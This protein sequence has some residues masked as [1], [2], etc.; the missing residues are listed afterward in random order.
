VLKSDGT[1]QN[2]LYLHRDYQGCILAITD[3]NAVVLEKR[4]FDAWG[5]LINYYNATGAPFGGWGAFDRGYTGHEHLQSV[6][7]IHMN[8]RLYDPKLHRFLQPDNFVQDPTNTQNYNRYGYCWNN[9]LKYTDPSGESFWKSLASIAVSVG[10][11]AVG[12]AVGIATGGAIGWVGYV[13]F[14]RG[15]WQVY[16]GGWGTIGTTPAA[17]F[18]NF[19]VM[20]GKFSF[21]GGV[22]ATPKF[23]G[24]GDKPKNGIEEN[25]NSNPMNVIKDDPKPNQIV[26]NENYNYS[27]S[28]LKVLRSMG[29]QNT[30]I[31]NN[32]YTEVNITKRPYQIIVGPVTPTDCL[33]ADDLGWILDTDKIDKIA[34]GIG[35]N[36]NVKEGM[37]ELAKKSGDI[38]RAGK[39]YLN[40]TKALG[41][42]TGI[43]GAGTAWYDYYN[44]PTTGGLVK[45]L[46]NTGLVFIRVNP[47]VGVGLGILDLTGGSDWFYN[48][49]GNGI[50]SMGGQGR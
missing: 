32:F 46:S 14:N 1:T 48:Q 47:F 20:D 25:N 36:M 28:D 2:Y 40:I 21:Y 31:F 4:Q 39:T 49:V 50:D 9:P 42:A 30:N 6:G 43:V 22:A 17:G 23:L 7:L 3:A 12:I 45:A 41:K 16:A 38:G 13:D 5:S 34:G 15:D 44:K 11:S 19:G 29:A 26:N 27:T 8:G 37:I 33:T 18:I 10:F 35:V 24:G